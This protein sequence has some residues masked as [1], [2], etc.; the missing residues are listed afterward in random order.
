MEIESFLTRHFPPLS[1]DSTSLQEYVTLANN[2]VDSFFNEYIFHNDNILDGVVN[3]KR[4]SILT[5]VLDT[6]IF[7]RFQ[8]IFQS[9]SHETL[10]SITRHSILEKATVGEILMAIE[11]INK[12]EITLAGAH[13][14][15]THT[16]MTKCHP[17]EGNS[18]RLITA[19]S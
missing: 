16:L 11:W 4:R 18:I 12:Y 15:S 2:A 8:P 1:D 5:R 6:A 9:D 10:S 13:C 19:I 17:S 14:L 7:E 3:T